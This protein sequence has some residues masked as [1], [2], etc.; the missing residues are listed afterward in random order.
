MTFIIFFLFKDGSTYVSKILE[1]LPFSQ[2]NKE[3]LAKQTKDV[4]VS[5]IYGGVAV[6]LAQGIVGTLGFISVGMSS[7]AL[8]GLTTA[9]TSF[10]P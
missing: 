7:P 6:A 3:R 9:M 4:V 8:W 10:I 1:Y 2:P 5:T